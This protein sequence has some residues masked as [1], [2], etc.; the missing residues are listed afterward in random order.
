MIIIIAYKKM[1]DTL[2][3]P[4]TL[5]SIIVGCIFELI[6]TCDL[7]RLSRGERRNCE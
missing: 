7:S 3:N 6:Q 4:I 5:F 1:F 2:F